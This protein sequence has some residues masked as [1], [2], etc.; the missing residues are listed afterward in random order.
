MGSGIGSIPLD[1]LVNAISGLLQATVPSGFKIAVKPVPLSEV[2][3][4]WIEDDSTQR[5]V[6]IVDEQKSIDLFK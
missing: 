3:Q 1:R 5:T 6:F 4:A 2:E